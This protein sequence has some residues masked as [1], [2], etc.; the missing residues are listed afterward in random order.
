MVATNI[1]AA[2]YADTLTLETLAELL[3]PQTALIPVKEISD[4]AYQIVLEDLALAL[5]CV[6]SSNVTITLPNDASV[7][8]AAAGAVSVSGAASGDAAVAGTANGT[9]SL[10]GAASGHVIAAGNASNT[11][12]LIGSST[13]RVLVR[14]MAAGTLTISVSAHS[15]GGSGDGGGGG[16]L[17]RSRTPVMAMLMRRRA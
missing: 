2:G 17:R 13:G 4:T 9:V 3:A 15:V 5:E 10:T 16:V 6:S 1:R 7:R 8:G 12:S 14:G 11:V